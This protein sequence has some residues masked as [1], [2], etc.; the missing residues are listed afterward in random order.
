MGQ[1]DRRKMRTGS[2]VEQVR[3]CV[4]SPK[5]TF[6]RSL[7]EKELLYCRASRGPGYTLM[8]TIQVMSSHYKS[9]S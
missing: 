8:F 5:G 9:C 2:R 4:V 6:W 3:T 7:P 1:K